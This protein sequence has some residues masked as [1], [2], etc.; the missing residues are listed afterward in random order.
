[1]YLNRLSVKQ[2]MQPHSCVCVNNVSVC[3]QMSSYGVLPVLPY[4]RVSVSCKQLISV[5]R[6]VHTVW[7][8]RASEYYSVIKTECSFFFFID[9]VWG[10]IIHI[11]NVFCYAI[12]DSLLFPS[13]PSQ[14][15]VSSLPFP[16]FMT[17]GLYC[18]PFSVTTAICE[19]SGLEPSIGRRGKTP[20]SCPVTST[21]A[22]LHSHTQLSMCTHTQ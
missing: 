10:K 17:L 9:L 12:P 15:Y 21:W 22:T 14:R 18:D 16:R 7:Y 11:Y 1:M 2:T 4:S 20:E 19:I 5:Y 8:L 6:W 3:P 13:H